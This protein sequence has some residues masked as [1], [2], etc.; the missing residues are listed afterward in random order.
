MYGGIDGR[1]VVQRKATDTEPATTVIR[2]EMYYSERPSETRKRA[3]RNVSELAYDLAET[4]GSTVAVV[5]EG[6][7]ALVIRLGSIAV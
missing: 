2:H 5:H 3:E 1:R 4:R 7:V 6:E